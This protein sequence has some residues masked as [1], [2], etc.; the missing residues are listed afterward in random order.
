MSPLMA[1][2][3]SRDPA[4]AGRPNWYDCIGHSPLKKESQSAG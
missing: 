2:P 1:S 4:I 3:A